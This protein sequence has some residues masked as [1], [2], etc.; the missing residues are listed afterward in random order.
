VSVRF[1]PEPGDDERAV[2]LQALGALDGRRDA[3]SPWWEAGVREA[4]EEGPE[5][6][7]G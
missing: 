3:P 5:P 2:L 4:V 6:E 7:E 1:R